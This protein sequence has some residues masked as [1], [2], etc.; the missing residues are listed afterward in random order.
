MASSARRTITCILV[1][2]G[3][4]ICVHAQ[5]TA[6]KV[7]SA[8]ISGKVTLKGKPLVGLTISARKVNHSGAESDTAYG[9]RTDQTGTYH[10]PNLP[11]GTYEVS[12]NA[13]ALV[14]I[15]DTDSVVVGEAEEVALNIQFVPGGVITG[16]I[17]DADGA[18]LIEQYVRLTPVAAN[19]QREWSS[20]T[21]ITRL[22]VNSTDDRG[23]YRVFGLPAGRYKVSV[24]DS[25]RRNSRKYYKE[26]YHPSVTDPAKATIIEVT[27]GGEATNV[28]IVMGRAVTTFRVL[29]RVVDGESGK[30]VPNTRYGVSQRIVYGESSGGSSSSSAISMSND[31][32]DANGEFRLENV[33]PGKYTI[34]TIT[35]EGSGI[36]AAAATFDVVDRDITDVLIKTTKGA[37][38]SGVVVLDGDPQTVRTLSSL[39]ICAMVEGKVGSFS[40]TAMSAV[41]H[42]GTFRIVG[43]QS[44]LA[45]LSLCSS[46]V[47]DRRFEIVRI[48]R[49]G[50]L[51]EK[52][53]IGERDDVAALRVFV[54]SVKM[55]GAIRGQLKVE[56]GELPPIS[57]FSLM[58]WPLDENFQMQRS[59]SIPSPQL[60]SRGRFFAERLPAG[61]YRISIWNAQAGRPPNETSQHVIVT[62][63]AVTEVT[64]TF[65]P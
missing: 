5:T 9:A 40:H 15:T 38:L 57:Q 49:N 65:K 13:P 26:T 35:P 61:A 63:D 59:H 37:S 18:P 31:V 44:G 10:I 42:D 24:V 30:P 12:S 47:N 36:P 16:K 45:L 64:L 51:V 2:V 46:D 48:E 22:H 1:V 58:L 4:L 20:P 53:A 28:D 14:S 54:K 39:K 33:A 29:G 3:G 32:T 11:A 8:R 6:E 19:M 25:G 7:K 23:V 34:F 17:T 27:E 56:N 41:G 52:V 21:L 50:L 55:T 60:D 43:V 62:D